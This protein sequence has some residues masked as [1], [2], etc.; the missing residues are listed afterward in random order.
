M[1]ITEIY[2]LHPIFEDALKKHNYL[3]RRTKDINLSTYIDEE[4]LLQ[5]II[6]TQKRNWEKLCNR[7]ANPKFKLLDA[8]K[9]KIIN[10]NVLNTLKTGIDVENISFDLF[11]PQP[12]ERATRTNSMDLY[13]KN[14][15]SYVHEFAYYKQEEIDFAIFINGFSICSFELKLSISKSGWNYEDAIK[16]YNKRAK[17]SIKNGVPNIFL[18]WEKG[19]LFHF[20]LDENLAYVTT[21]IT[22][23]SYFIPFNK[24]VGSGKDKAAGNDRSQD[25]PTEYVWKEI[26]RKDVLADILYNFVFYEV[27]KDDDDNIIDKKLIFPRYHQLKAVTKLVNDIKENRTSNN[28]LI[29]HSAGSGKSNTILWLAHRFSSIRDNQGN[30]VF[31]S[32]IILND[33]NVVIKQLQSGIQNLDTEVGEVF[34]VTSDKST[35]LARAIDL[36]KHII[37]CT[38]QSFLNAEKK[39]KESCKDKKFAVIIDE[40]HSSTDGKDIIAVNKSLSTNEDVYDRLYRENSRGDKPNNISFIGFTA[41]PKPSTLKRFGIEVENENGE[42][43]YAPFDVYSMKQAIQ[44][45]FILDV[46]SS[47]MIVDA[48]CSILKISMDNPELEK[49]KGKKILDK[50]IKR[51]AV[52]LSEKVEIIMEHFI[53]N[54]YMKLNGEAKAMIVT[55]S[56]EDVL[57]YK[58]AIEEYVRNSELPIDDI[59]ALVAFSGNLNDQK[60]SYY[61]NNIKN[62]EKK[63]DSNKYQLLIVANKY[64]TGYDQPKLCV[65]YIDKKL[66]GVQAVQTLSRL[67]RPYKNKSIYILDFINTYE[68]IKAAFEDYYET[69]SLCTNVSMISLE[70]LYNEIIG[71]GI[72]TDT[73]LDLFTT[74]N[75]KSIEEKTVD[76]SYNLIAI[77]YRTKKEIDDRE[78]SKVIIATCS[79]YKKMYVLLNQVAEVKN[80]EYEKWFILLE[81]ILNKYSSNSGGSR[82]NKSII[83]MLREKTIIVKDAETEVI[84][85]KTISLESTGE[86]KENIDGTVPKEIGEPVIDTLENIVRE[87]NQEIQ[88]AGVYEEAIKQILK[89][90]NNDIGLAVYAKKN[91]N[92][93]DFEDVFNKEYNTKLIKLKQDHI[94]NIAEWRY[95]NKSDLKKKLMQKTYY[96]FR[97]EGVL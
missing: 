95:L 61:N 36:G 51:E 19:A 74:I 47:Y 68:E 29:Q 62:I 24:G 18:D 66:E 78:N 82:Q 93:S 6:D 71:Y 16:Q 50:F 75:A 65:M 1:S 73:D 81:S 85:V 59:N 21:H 30:N 33:R 40:S 32:V 96:E 92:I 63:F 5:F 90:I 23:D 44:E 60:E 43:Y 34:C 27:K 2:D 53:K 9:D 45:G 79:K 56:R 41:T 97:K 10:S 35:K 25:I 14:I 20:A 26:L 77:Q 39:L 87:V 49:Y 46:L 89:A 38:I 83:E 11:Y 70:A 58:E 94:I 42:K 80:K 28:Y 31:D 55:S 76:D 67:N 7:S 3:T 8:I 69:T 15:F 17:T 54:V 86:L 52:S 84:Q 13:E 57:L 64:Q 48:H 91:N 12:E 88:G 37:I 4:L 22:K 72:I